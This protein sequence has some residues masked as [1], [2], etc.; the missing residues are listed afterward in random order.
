MTK[1]LYYTDSSLT[2]FE[3]TVVSADPVDG[4]VHVAL[5]ATDYFQ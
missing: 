4:R 5:D 3:A 1:R 2:S